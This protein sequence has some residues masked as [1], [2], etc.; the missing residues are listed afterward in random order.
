MLTLI[1]SEC[2]RESKSE[3]FN[4]EWEAYL[5]AKHIWLVE[6]DPLVYRSVISP[7]YGFLWGSATPGSVSGLTA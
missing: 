7:K 5:P 6:G 1:G 3:I 4:A 2:C